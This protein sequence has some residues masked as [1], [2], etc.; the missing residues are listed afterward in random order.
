M[1]FRLWSGKITFMFSFKWSYGIIN[2]C[3]KVYGIR[4]TYEGECYMA[5]NKKKEMNKAQTAKRK[6]VNTLKSLIVFAA[7]IL[8][9]T[10]V[11]L[12][13][14]MVMKVLHLNNQIDKLYSTEHTVEVL[15]TFNL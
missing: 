12:N 11:I 5:E 8:L 10:S 7:V 13:F 1:P 14:I 6:R 4:I 3:V 9:F 2:Y 15:N